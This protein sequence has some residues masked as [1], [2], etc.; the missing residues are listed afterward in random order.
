MEVAHWKDVHERLDTHPAAAWVLFDRAPLTSFEDALEDI[1]NHD[2][3]MAKTLRSDYWEAY[4]F[5][6]VR[7]FLRRG[8]RPFTTAS[9]FPG[10][11]VVRDGGSPSTGALAPNSPKVP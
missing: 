2:A 6:A 3:A 1:E 8:A 10:N 4:A 9:E 11:G 5:G 7:V